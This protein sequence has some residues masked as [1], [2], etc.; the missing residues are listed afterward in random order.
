[1]KLETGTRVWLRDSVHGWIGAAVTGTSAGSKSDELVHLRTSNGPTQ[2]AVN[3]TDDHPPLRSFTQEQNFVDDLNQ[4]HL[5]N[6][7]NLLIT[8]RSRFERRIIYTYSGL[9]LVALNPYADTS[10]Y[11]NDHILHYASDNP[12]SQPHIYSVARS[13]YDGICNAK[14]NQTII[15]SGES[16]AG[17]T[18][19][20]RHIMRYFAVAG[21]TKDKNTITSTEERILATN[22][23]MEAFG[24]AKTL[25]NSNSSRFGR[26]LQIYFDDKSSIV[27]A[28]IR[29]FL[30]ERSRLVYQPH[31]E[32]NT[33]IFYQL[34]A[35]LKTDFSLKRELKLG[36]A[37]E[38]NYLNQG[39]CSRLPGV[40]DAFNFDITR[41]AMTSLGIDNSTQ[42]QIFRLLAALLHLGNI[43]IKQ[44][45]STRQDASVSIT[46]S[47]LLHAAELLGISAIAFQKGLMHK[48][49]G[50]GRIRAESE[51]IVTSLNKDQA[52]T[53]R[54]SLGRHIYTRLFDWLVIKL[55]STLLSKESGA[56]DSAR[57]FVGVLDIYGF[58]HFHKNSFE[59]FCINYANEKLQQEFY[60]HTFKLSQEEYDR[61]GLKVAYINYP[62]NQPCI[63]MIESRVGL[64]ALLD[65][66]CRL[67]AGTDAG[68]R[69]KMDE[70]LRSPYKKALFS[71]SKSNS[72][73]AGA[74]TVAHYAQDV[75]YDV[76]G[77][78]EKNRDSVPEEHK[79]LLN[80]AQNSFVKEVCTAD[81]TPTTPPS[82]VSTPTQ[83]LKTPLQAVHSPPS[84]SSVDELSSA[85]SKGHIRSPSTIPP[86]WPPASPGSPSLS[87]PTLRKQPTLGGTFK[88]SLNNLMTTIND[89]DTHYIRC[90][91]PA[92]Q[93]NASWSFDNQKVLSQLRAS[94][95]LETIRISRAGYPSKMTFDKFVEK[96]DI[97]ISQRETKLKSNNDRKASFKILEGTITNKTL[98]AI[99]RTKVFMRVGVLAH[100]DKLRSILLA[101]IVA[102]QA[103]ARSTISTKRY[104][105]HQASIAVEAKLYVSLQAV[106]RTKLVMLRVGE[107]LTQRL[108]NVRIRHAEKERWERKALAQA[109]KENAR[110]SNAW[111]APDANVDVNVNTNLGVRRPEKSPIR[112][113]NSAGKGDDEEVI[114]TGSVEVLEH[115]RKVFHHA[116]KPSFASSLASS[117][118]S[119]SSY[120]TAYMDEII[121]PTKPPRNA[122]RNSRNVTPNSDTSSRTSTGRT[123]S[124][125]R[126]PTPTPPE[127]TTSLSNANDPRVNKRSS[128]AVIHAR[129]SQVLWSV[130]E[131]A[132]DR[133]SAHRFPRKQTSDE[134]VTTHDLRTIPKTTMASSFNIFN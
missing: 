35:G 116:N 52:T 19:S 110:L 22:P 87:A 129:I 86:S 77:F 84:R 20:A 2:I 105:R 49:I 55:N 108:E 15:V 92:N 102:I 23:V 62:D 27:G 111:M 131:K 46:D 10:I 7:P 47:S 41:R 42:K 93:E 54:D 97:L 67:P 45:S 89:T 18:V 121:P 119:S 9:V 61:E 48:T 14:R 70:M 127:R 120:A 106:S 74:F 31:N 99:G 72:L 73:G 24:N 21:K 103:S 66:Q 80:E 95:V 112:Y 8:L 5:L 94:G 96:Y 32:R 17:K 64:L 38:Y 12:P 16:G 13:A 88:M 124:I 78:L 44:T 36:S 43:E 123:S 56:S 126:G 118:T 98:Y 34:C 60:N 33:H 132:I 71:G 109:E 51:K 50:V 29:I 83:P 6:E 115:S 28:H 4:L 134:V 3:N 37:D 104:I 133:D 58:E 69:T 81:L 57:Q 76:D 63:E 117:L 75:T 1:M 130:L 107:A 25:R 26:Y 113:Q 82:I 39:Q 59:Q 30:L 101:R 128:R 68:L 91:K 90:I 40:D 85:F 114:G 65:E 122:A 100:L 125:I 11:S 53:A 79:N